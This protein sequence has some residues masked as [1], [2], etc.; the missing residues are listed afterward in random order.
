M[1][2]NKRGII[3]FVAVALVAPNI[4]S[5]ALGLGT[6][7]LINRIFDMAVAIICGI[8][9]GYVTA[10]VT[11][12]NRLIKAEQKF[13]SNAWNAFTSKVPEATWFG[14]TAHADVTATAAQNCKDCPPRD[15]PVIDVFR[16]FCG[17]VVG[18]IVIYA[19]ANNG[20]MGNN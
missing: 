2:D 11:I 19:C 8:A 10:A 7:M 13:A 12:A 17:A 9:Q 4:L 18:A 1:Q 14:G 16:Q 20:H 5:A 6:E 3:I 15:H